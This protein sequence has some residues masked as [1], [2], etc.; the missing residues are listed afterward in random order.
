MVAK[1]CSMAGCKA[2]CAEAIGT[3]NQL[4]ALAAIP[5]A[6]Q[7]TPV[8]AI[9]ASGRAGRVSM[10]NAGWKCVAWQM[11]LPWPTILPITY[12]HPDPRWTGCGAKGRRRGFWV[13]EPRF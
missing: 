7:R 3:H 12:R 4:N 2:G 6:A 11:A 1:C 5:A 10:S 13:L 9:D 8:L